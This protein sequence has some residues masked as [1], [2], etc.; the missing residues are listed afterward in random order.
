MK[1]SIRKVLTVTA[2]SVALGLPGAVFCQVG[3]APTQPEQKP[4]T[5]PPDH[6]ATVEG[7]VD[8]QNM[9]RGSV[10]LTRSM[11][12]KKD[13]DG[14]QFEAKLT[15]TV[16][17]KSGKKL[18]KGTVLVG[19]VANDDMQESGRSKLAVRFTEAK[20]GNGETIPI[21]ATIIQV[22]PP[23]GLTADGSPLPDESGPAYDLDDHAN[24]WNSRQLDVDQ[25]GA[26]RNVD[27]HSRLASQNSGVFVS[28]K[29]DD[30]KLM[31]GSQF[32]LAIAEQGNGQQAK[33]Q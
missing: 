33:N 32:E 2:V 22:Y 25:I 8:A 23:V 20:L 14:S 19:M 3:V 7:R 11:D 24:E 16:H 21:K 15:R 6:P 10:A 27:L 5:S 4:Q 17:L 31:K 9:V 30:V 18:D 1:R 13:R 26:L 12:A 29:S 28:T